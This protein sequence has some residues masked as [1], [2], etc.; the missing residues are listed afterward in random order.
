MRTA[1]N[2]GD[3][4]VP[5]CERVSTT[6]RYGRERRGFRMA[7]AERAVLDGAMTAADEL[8]L[9]R[10]G[11]DTVGKNRV[12]GGARNKSGPDA[13]GGAVGGGRYG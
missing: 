9:R 2:A 1:F 11:H 6:A 3:S 4:G 10:H 13:R 12:A 8:Q 5:L 7:P